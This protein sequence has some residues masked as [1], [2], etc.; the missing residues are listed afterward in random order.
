[1]V[2]SGPAPSSRAQARDV[3]MT[4]LGW[5]GNYSDYELL[6]DLVG[7]RR[8]VYPAGAQQSAEVFE[9]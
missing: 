7:V 4:H 1:M 2:V 8:A 5:P 3:R 9:D 6:T